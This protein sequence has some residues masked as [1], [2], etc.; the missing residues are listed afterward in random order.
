MTSPWTLCV[1]TDDRLARGR[2]HLEIVAAAIAGGATSI[3]YRAKDAT[4]RRMIEEAGALA[5]LCR[6]SGV[7]LLVNDRLDVALAVDAD[8][9][10]L[11]QDDL[12]ASLARA[13]LGSGRLIG[14]T[15]PT[16]DAALQA[17]RDGA[18]YVGSGPFAAT[19]TK[20]V[21][22]PILGAAGLAAIARACRIPVVAIG[23]IDA[24]AAGRA[25]A[26]GAT[27]VAVVAAVVAADDPREAAAAI[28]AC[29]GR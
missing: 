2:S 12:P 14:V 15:A 13:I 7:P 18:D 20:D 21:R 8:G 6:G 29:L 17:E 19:A 3:Q 1:L 16:V 10:H 4:T 5:A 26:A 27:G 22:R 23:G 24:E 11:G 25:A 9:V 28:R